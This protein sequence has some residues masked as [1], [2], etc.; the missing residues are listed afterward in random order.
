ML[1]KCLF[2]NY[3]KGFLNFGVFSE[4]KVMKRELLISLFCKTFI[5][6]SWFFL[7]MQKRIEVNGKELFVSKASSY[8]NCIEEA[9]SII[10]SSRFFKGLKETDKVL[11]KPNFL[12]ARKESDAVNTN[13]RIVEAAIISFKKKLSKDNIIVGDSPG[14]AS[15]LAVAKACGVYDVC[16]RHGIKIVEFSSHKLVGLKTFRR[17]SLW[18]NYDEFKIVNLPKIKTHVF[19][20]F[21]CA[22]KNLYGLIPGKVKAGYHLTHPVPAD[23]GRLLYELALKVNPEFT[24]VDGI[25]GLEGNGPGSAGIPIKTGVLIGSDN[26]F[27]ADFAACSAAGIDYRIIPYMVAAAREKSIN[28]SALSKGLSGL[29]FPLAS[30]RLPDGKKLVSRITHSR[31]ARRVFRRFSSKP[32][33]I[34]NACI[35]C[36]ECKRICPAEAISM[37][38]YA[39]IDYSKC[40]RCFCCHEIC[41]AKAIEVAKGIDSFLRM[42]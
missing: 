31:L 11:L 21:T 35:K 25:I 23:F 32:R 3:L 39:K 36:G 41:P 13:P 5:T 27:V 1:F 34:T 28:L 14:T 9:C 7:C 24:L 38:P 16:K 37:S 30:Y 29:G 33:V 19:M 18:E 15:A 4:I 8:D 12:S 20:T 6:H 10:E 26:V 17:I 22:V 2:G 42:R 40:I